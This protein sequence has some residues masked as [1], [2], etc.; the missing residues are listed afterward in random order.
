MVVKALKSSTLLHLLSDEEVRYGDPLSFKGLSLVPLFTVRAAPFDYVLVARAVAAG[1]F[2]IEEVGRGTVPT[3]R[4]V[5]KGDRPVL[6]IDGE[7]LVGVKQNRV[8]NTTML[9]PEKT[10]LDIPVSC[11]ERGRWSAPRDA[12]RPASP[13][14]F[15]GTRAAQAEAVTA[16]VRDSGVYKSDQNMIWARVDDTL[17]SLAAV[18]PT[19]S[20]HAAYE[21][22]AGDVG[23]YLAN[24]RWQPGQTGVVAGVGGRIVCADLF[25]RPTTM[26]MLWDRL[27]PSYAVEAM[28]KRDW[29]GRTLEALGGGVTVADAAAHAEVFLR[30]ARNAQITEH[31]AIGRGTDLRITGDGLVGAALE[32]D[33]A[34]VHLAMFRTEGR[35][36]WRVTQ[37]PFATMAERRARFPQS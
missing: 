15:V 27:I 36:P 34:I 17:S 22:R 33:G 29:M 24:L 30:G 26:E 35:G 31:P 4:V 5:N 37:P 14:L 28:S 11:V 21:Q 1:T 18:S 13:Y 19:S 2:V 32:V 23:E 7:H 3:L 12:A 8:L 9:V 25:D 16:S 10:A 6:L 20:M